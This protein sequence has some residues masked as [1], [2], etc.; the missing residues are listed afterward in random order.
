M[1]EGAESRGAEG[2]IRYSPEAS[3]AERNEG[4]VLGRIMACIGPV[5]AFSDNERN[6]LFYDA[7]AE[8]VNYEG[9]PERLH[10]LGQK[11]AGYN[12]YVISRVGPENKHSG[13]YLNCTGFAVVGVDRETNQNISILSH[14][15]PASFLV[16]DKQ[17]FSEDVSSVLGE[18]MSRVKPDTVDAVIF[19]GDYLSDKAYTGT[20]GTRADDYR[21]SIKQLRKILRPLIHK[22]PEVVIGPLTEADEVDAALD[23]KNRRLYLV[24]PVQFGDPNTDISFKALDVENV[25]QE[26]DASVAAPLGEYL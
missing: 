22:E 21:A 5:E 23:T 3:A 24:R 13:G 12:S 15:D 10:E 26:W 4:P 6:E 16:K 1:P 9:T 8:Y 11:N 17:R 25:A 18:F 19:G 7:E 20:G 2:G 14:E